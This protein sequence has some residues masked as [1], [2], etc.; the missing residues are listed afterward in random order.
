MDLDQYEVG[1][2]ISQ[3]GLSA[4]SFGVANSDVAIVGNALMSYFGYK[5]LPPMTIVPGD[6]PELQS[7]CENPTCPLAADPECWLYAS[8]TPPA[9][10]SQSAT[11]SSYGQKSSEYAS[12][13]SSSYGQKSSEY[14]SS[15]SSAYGQKS[16]EYASS[17][18][19]AHGEKSSK[20]AYSSMLQRANMA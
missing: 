18:S 13:T 20:Y 10:V 4:A 16:S 9:P 11:S 12:S 5:C 8:P 2:F 17:T 3:V 19:S 15:T 7:I 1:Y 6:G 14:A